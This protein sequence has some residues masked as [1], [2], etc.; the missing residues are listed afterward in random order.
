MVLQ[1][2][3]LG[4]EVHVL[5]GLLHEP[6]ELL[7][8]LGGHRVEHAL[9]G[10]RPAR[11]VVEQLLEALRTIGEELP[12]LVHELLEVLAHIL[13]AP[14]LVEHRIEVGQHVLHRLLLLRRSGILQ[15]L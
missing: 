10:G 9:H 11:E 1:L 7:A 2:R 5:P 14:M 13:A 3:H 15:C 6:G 8:L 12:V 4:C